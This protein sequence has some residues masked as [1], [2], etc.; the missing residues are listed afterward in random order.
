MGLFGSS[1]DYSGVEK[2][3]DQSMQQILEQIKTAQAQ[4][5]TDIADA[6][7]KAYGINQPYMQAGTSALNSYLDTLGIGPK[8]AAG[9]SSLRDQFQQSPGFQYQ[10]QQAT[11]A[12]T[13]R[14]AAS[15]QTMSGAETRELASQSQGLASQ[16]WNNW[17]TNSQNRLADIA[18]M[19]QRSAT[20]QAGFETQGGL[21]LANLGL[22]YSKMSTEEMQAAAKAKAE[23]EMAQQTQNAQ[24]KNS[25]LGGIGSLVGAGAGFLSGG[26]IP[27]M[28]MGATLGGGI[29]GG[30]NKPNYSSFAN[31]NMYSNPYMFNQNQSSN[32]W[33]NNYSGWQQQVNPQRWLS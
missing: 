33:L 15:G 10:L 28:A 24:S 18:G 21:S 29:G 11:N 8:G 5:R 1:V 20:Q 30:Q 12:A 19:G 14:A 32:S 23:A 7:S 25:W 3:Y 22:D 31:P 26:G 17:L 9:P 16:D 27:G 13:R 2:T 4:G 6:L